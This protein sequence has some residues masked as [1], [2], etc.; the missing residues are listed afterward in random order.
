MS[1]G[2]AVHSNGTRAPARLRRRRR[3]QCC[4]APGARRAPAMI[5]RRMIRGRCSVLRKAAHDDAATTRV[6]PSAP[7]TTPPARKATAAAGPV[8]TIHRC[9]SAAHRPHTYG[10][11]PLAA[12]ATSRA[13]A[14][15]PV[16][17]C[18]ARCRGRCRGQWRRR[19]GFGRGRAGGP[20]GKERG[21]EHLHA[22]S[23]RASVAV[24]RADL[25]V[26]GRIPA[27]AFDID[28]LDRR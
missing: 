3:Q 20:V 2:A 27:L 9:C 22:R 16:A 26:C 7:M 21:G 15:V 28:G 8:D 24:A 17:H 12:L 18:R 23:P 6:T 13:G 10:D 11:V 14:S 4:C 25:N 5:R 1:G 19:R